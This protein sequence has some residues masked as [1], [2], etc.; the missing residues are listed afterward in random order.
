MPLTPFTN[1]TILTQPQIMLSTGSSDFSG[2]NAIDLSGYSN[3]I[4]ISRTFDQHDV[5]VFGQTDH[6][7]ALGLGKWQA[8]IEVLQEYASGGI[9]AK[10]WPIVG[11]ASPW[12]MFVRHVYGNRTSS[13][14]EYTGPVRIADYNPI[15]GQIGD[16]LKNA[17]TLVGADSLSRTVTSS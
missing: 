2:A 15:N 9:D 16:P 10:L 13:N 7:K 8:Q 3:R 1:V 17:I 14:P 4:Q 5:T 12:F 6:A 11:S